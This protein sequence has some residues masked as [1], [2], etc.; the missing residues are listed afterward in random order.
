L[1]ND[2]Q[3]DPVRIVKRKSDRFPALSVAKAASTPAPE[4]PSANSAALDNRHPTEDKSS[5]SQPDRQ[6][7]HAKDSSKMA[8]DS[9]REGPKTQQ[10][11][12]EP[13]HGERNAKYRFDPDSEDEEMEAEIDA[14]LA[15]GLRIP[16]STAL[17]QV[18]RKTDALSDEVS[19]MRP[20][21]RLKPGTMM[22]RP[23]AGGEGDGWR[24]NV[25]SAT[26]KEDVERPVRIRRI[27]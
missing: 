24:F 1:N 26:P 18:M 16:H 19:G 3:N 12:P 15:P 5:S 20:I 14:V 13:S 17:E 2:D 25:A 8:K 23:L 22:G 7:E 10:S 21:Q 9:G 27:E 4:A 6:V 11:R